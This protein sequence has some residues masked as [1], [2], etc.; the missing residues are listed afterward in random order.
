MARSLIPDGVWEEISL[1]YPSGGGKAAQEVL[2][3]HGFDGVVKYDSIAKRMNMRGLRADRYRKSGEVRQAA[4]PSAPVGDFWDDDGEGLPFAVRRRCM[5]RDCIE[6]FTPVNDG[7]W[8]HHPDCRRSERLWTKEEILAEEGSLYPEASGTEMAARA[9]GQKN[10]LQRKVQQLTSQREF[11]RYQV[12]KVLTENR[13]L[14]PERRQPGP[15]DVDKPKGAREVIVLCSDWQVGKME[16]GIGVRAVVEQRVPRLMAATY[17]I[18][19]QYRDSGY[20]VD[21]AH[22]V[23]AGDMLEGCLPAGTLVDTP[24]GPKPI[25]SFI[26]GDEVWALGREGF[27]RAIVSAAAMTGIDPLYTIR[28]RDRTVRAN[29]EHP[30]LV[31]RRTEVSGSSYRNRHRYEV[32]LNYVRA[33]EVQPGDLVAMVERFSDGGNAATPLGTDAS[34]ELMEFLGLYLGDGCL[35][36]GRDGKPNVVCIA[37]AENAVQWIARYLEG[38]EKVFFKANG[39]PVKFSAWSDGMARFGSTAAAQM[40]LDLGLGGRAREKRVPGWVFGLRRDLRA[41]FLRGYIDSDGHVTKD[42]VV[43]FG[44]VNGQL[45]EDIRHLCDGLGLVATEVHYRPGRTKLPTGRIIERD[46]YTLTLGAP[47]LNC[48]IGSHDPRYQERFSA[49]QRTQPRR[50]PE[51]RTDLKGWIAPLAGTRYTKVLEVSKS[52]LAEPVYNLTVEGLENYTA[53]GLVGHNCFIYA[54]Q[55]ITGLDRSGNSH[56][57]TKQIMVTADLQA[58][59]AMDLASYVKGVDVYSVPGNHGRANGKNDF[60]DPEDNF[61]SL[62]CMWARDKA[63]LQDNINWH[64]EENWWSRFSVCGHQVV[65]MHG[66][67]WHGPLIKIRELLPQWT[68]ADIFGA[69][70]EL[71]LLGHRHEF[72]MLE[73]N[74]VPVI[75]NG[76]LDGGSNWYLRA[77]GKASRPTQTV[78]ISSGKRLVEAV[79]PIYMDHE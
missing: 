75:Q 69:R 70:P 63:Q 7:H 57:L 5:N 29:G 15:G 38:A 9:F 64:I 33:G 35:G 22:L 61:D 78:I 44:S 60:A 23:F 43:V 55:N 42:G 25:E 52:S 3:R 65:A 56:R 46:L 27:E 41:A 68:L 72:S 8:Y 45:M 48:E 59:V 18:V 28:T 21:R 12:N 54:G 6:R 17:E 66:D 51:Y 36:R 31:M 76:T 74:G 67:Q 73:V 62:A 77:Y 32:T 2:R 37:F 58:G 4:E 20:S 1:V 19:K 11:L 13:W 49:G 26:A 71:L 10:R 30:F 40:I 79:Y 14:L 39:D 53:N 50:R 16:N 34:V 24:D 47:S